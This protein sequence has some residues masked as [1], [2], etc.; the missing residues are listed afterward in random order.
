MPN[1]VTGNLAADFLTGLA[2]GFRSG[3]ETAIALQ[4]R[5]RRQQ[6]EDEERRYRA[7]EAERRAR[8]AALREAEFSERT[9]I[10]Y[11][12]TTIPEFR[13]PFQ[14]VQDPAELMRGRIAEI[15]Q[16][17]GRQL[18][19]AGAAADPLTTPFRAAPVPAFERP[20]EFGGF[21][22][23]GPSQE[24]RQSA[25]ASEREA[26]LT[27]LIGSTI[28]RLRPELGIATD[29]P[30]A[31]ALGTGRVPLPEPRPPVRGQFLQTDQGWAFGDLTTG[32]IRPVGIQLPP[33]ASTERP[34]TETQSKMRVAL[35]RAEPALRQI[36]AFLGY[37]PATDSFAPG[38]GRVPEESFLG[39]YT[40]GRYFQSPEVQAY[41]QAAEA[42]VSAILRIESG[43]AI[44][45]QELESYK[46]QFIPRPGDRPEVIRQ[47]LQTL[48]ATLD[49]IRQ[50]SGAEGAPAAPAP[51]P[52]ATA[53]AAP[54]GAT[55]A[56]TP[57][58][59]F[60]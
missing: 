23:V 15:R 3:A 56:A 1:G 19:G 50:A 29:S 26:R 18:L 14:A 35:S 57:R 60:R 16:G 28:A 30:E 9:G 6:I 58:N 44:T 36:E 38:R 22:K 32:D 21:R 4:D 45:E 11:V 31:M 52:M 8:E 13:D 41:D 7:A 48:R 27:A 51:M 42:L 25:E 2:G 20:I 37:D 43:A 34:P 55:A 39:R 54:A 53:P 24:E 10:R 12:P 47:K 59:P 5:R 46:R 17:V 40:P 49:A 33:R